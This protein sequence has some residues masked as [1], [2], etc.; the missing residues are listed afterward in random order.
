MSI[1]HQKRKSLKTLAVAVAAATTL[2]A[3][4]MAT[5]LIGSDFDPELSITV[6]DTVFGQTVILENL[7]ETDIRLD[8]LPSLLSSS[9][10]A[11]TDKKML[12]SAGKTFAINLDA[13]GNVIS[14]SAWHTLNQARRKNV[15]SPRLVRA[16]IHVYPKNLT[17]GRVTSNY[18]LPLA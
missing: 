8:S 4:V 10:K 18:T 9:R 14:R 2:T 7:T 3:P 13:D 16:S 15:S 6:V 11:I 1:N 17:T 12:L 5:A